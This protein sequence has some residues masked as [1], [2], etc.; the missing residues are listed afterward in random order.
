MIREN[1]G[2]IVQIVGPVVDV[3]FS[4]GQLPEIYDAVEV[5]RN[6]DRLILEAQKHRE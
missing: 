3:E 6:G 2:K 1:E 4:T 5:P